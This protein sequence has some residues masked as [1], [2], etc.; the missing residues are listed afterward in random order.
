MWKAQLSNCLDLRPT[1]L[2]LQ[3]VSRGVAEKRIDIRLPDRLPC[4]VP[5]SIG[6]P[7]QF[8]EKFQSLSYTADA[9][10]LNR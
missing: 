10:Q 2:L 4:I 7:L 6:S 3:A 9:A 8:F 5:D 1:F